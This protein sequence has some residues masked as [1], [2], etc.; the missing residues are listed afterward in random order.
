MQSLEEQG[1]IVIRLFEDEDLIQSLKALCR[2]RQVKTAVVVSAVG[3]IKKFTLG[4]FDRKQYI[5][6]EYSEVYELI[7]VSG[8]FS[9]NSQ[10]ADYEFHL[11]AT[12]G[13]MSCQVF[14]G[15]LFSGIVHSSN[16]I[17]LLKSEMKVRRE[18]DQDT[19]T[20]RLCLE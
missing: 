13:N 7:S 9:L 18:L 2:Q 1:M 17:V 12:V 11:H 10:I 20:M 5:K 14:G 8:I 16:E 6:R 19:G 15:H 4:Y 3:Q